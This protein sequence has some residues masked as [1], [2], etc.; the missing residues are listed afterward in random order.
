LEQD[1]LIRLAG[2]LHFPLCSFT[3]SFGGGLTVKGDFHD[4]AGQPA[5]VVFIEMGYN[6]DNN[7]SP[8]EAV[9]RMRHRK[10]YNVLK[11]AASHVKFVIL[12]HQP[13]YR[14]TCPPKKKKKRPPPAWTHGALVEGSKWTDEAMK[15]VEELGI[16][17]ICLRT[18]PEE[19]FGGM[20]VADAAGAAWQA[21]GRSY[22]QHGIDYTE[23]GD[24]AL[25]ED[26][27]H[28]TVA[29]A[30]EHFRC[31]V[32]AFRARYESA[33]AIADPAVASSGPAEM[34]NRERSRSRDGQRAAPNSVF[35]KW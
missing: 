23:G 27:W 1:D 7:I 28:P 35:Y 33:V 17:A 5:E 21:G 11:A 18:S 25:W 19:L 6:D 10:W 13:S 29:G 8:E 32:K 12:V 31:L 4:P 15:L 3:S 34:N 30:E 2:D 14:Q 16:Q 26:C 9:R 20:L 24:L 22:T